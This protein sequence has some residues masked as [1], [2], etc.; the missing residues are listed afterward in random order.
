MSGL[1]DNQLAQLDNLIYYISNDSRIDL[2]H[3][4]SVQDVVQLAA[5]NID[6][7]LVGTPSRCISI[8]A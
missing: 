6:K 2:S 4:P 8:D 5:Q 7:S 3:S 1:S